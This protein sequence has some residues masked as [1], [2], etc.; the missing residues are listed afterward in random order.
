MPRYE[1]AEMREQRASLVTQLRSIDELATS[2]DRNLTAEEAQEFDRIDSEIR[3]LD[4]NIARHERLEGLVPQAEKREIVSDEEAREIFGS[5]AETREVSTF[6]TTEYRSAFDQYLRGGASQVAPELRAALTVG[7]N[8]QGGYT[9][10]ADWNRQLIEQLRLFGSIRPLATV[11]QTADSG[12]FH[13]PYVDTRATAALTTEAASYT[14]SEDTFNEVALGAYKIGIIVKASEEII[15]DSIFDLNGFIQRSAGQAIGLKE[16]NYFV[17][18]TG[19]SQPKG[20]TVAASTGVT[21]A[22][23]T[24][25]TADE[26]M[27]L[28]HSVV[29]PYRR[30]SSWLMNDAT[31]L[32]VR[33]LKDSQ[34]RYLWE[35]SIQV[36]DPDT[37]LG[38]PVYADPD[39]PT[40]ATGQKAVVFGDI[41]R[42]A[43]RDVEPTAVQYLDQ[44][45]AAN[46]QVAWKVHRRTDGNLTDPSAVKVLAMA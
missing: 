33:K 21:A 13:V 18:G 15:H 35:P 25:V 38:R 14:E 32:A 22:S 7:T 31:I 36:G 24:A 6:E 39:V 5:D 23:S 30:S 28:F 12:T 44:L 46:G 45:Y 19:S 27:G 11:Y 26:L 34:N 10:A 8:S 17:L 1:S 40:M 4:A 41:S 9:V 20:I 29:P 42:Y 43:I 37:L 2:E 16:N 3:D